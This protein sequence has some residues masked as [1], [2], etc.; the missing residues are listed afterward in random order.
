MNLLPEALAWWNRGYTVIAPSGGRTHPTGRPWTVLGGSRDTIPTLT[1]DELDA[2]HAIACTLD[3]MPA[4]GGTSPDQRT[5]TQA[6]GAGI[7]PEGA[8]D[9]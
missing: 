2:L 9:R 3:Q 1:V 5:R 7:H 8:C 4:L 6:A